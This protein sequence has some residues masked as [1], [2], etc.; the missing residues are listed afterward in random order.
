VLLKK[1]SFVS[2]QRNEIGVC[3]SYLSSCV[4]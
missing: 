3:S 4:V 2:V 1:L